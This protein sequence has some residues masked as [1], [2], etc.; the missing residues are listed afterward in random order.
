[1]NWN[2]KGIVAWRFMKDWNLQV[3]GEYEGARIQPQ[4]RSLPQY[5]LDLS[6]GHDISKKVTAVLA[7]NDVFFTRRWGNIIDTDR[8]YQESFRRREMR[9]VRFTLTWKFGEQNTS[10]FRRRNNQRQEPGGGDMEMP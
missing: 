4:G 1:M 8:L 10:L 5:G 7:V 3:N 2:A 9:F 6:I